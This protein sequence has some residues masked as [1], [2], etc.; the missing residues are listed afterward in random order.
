ML[1]QAFH[2]QEDL[3]I[4]NALPAALIAL[5]VVLLLDRFRFWQDGNHKTST[6]RDIPHGQVLLIVD[7]CNGPIRFDRDLFLSSHNNN[8]KSAWS[9]SISLLHVVNDENRGDRIHLVQALDRF[10]AVQERWLGRAEVYFDGLG[11][12]KQ[13]KFELAGREWDL[14][15]LVGLK[16][17]PVREEAD[18]V[19]VELVQQRRSNISEPLPNQDTLDLQ[20]CCDRISHSS[21]DV[22]DEEAFVFLRNSNGSGRSRQLV[23]RFGMM[24]P[25][26]VF[27]LFGFAESCHTARDAKSMSAIRH[28][29]SKLDRHSFDDIQSQRR[30]TIVA[31]DDVFLRQRIVEAGGL[32]MTFEQLW[33][34]LVPTSRIR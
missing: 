11:V 32:V 10:V 23:K 8:N 29:L 34:L 6:A 20:D 3:S 21:N 33:E 28:L 5:I 17:T 13:S 2:S 27:C 7:G 25:D 1:G 22:K 9:Q 16:V 30:E 19:I 26:S 14:T 24:R 15:D 4:A 18:N 12:D 31:T